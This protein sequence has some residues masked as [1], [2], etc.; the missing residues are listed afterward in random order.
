MCELD[1]MISAGCK[2]KEQG[3]AVLVFGRTG[4]LAENLKQLIVSDALCVDALSYCTPLEQVA[5]IGSVQVVIIEVNTSSDFKEVI[6]FVTKVRLQN[7][8]A[9]ISLVFAYSG[10]I[11]KV[12]CYLAGADHC[13]KLPVDH[14]EKTSLLSEMFENFESE[15][16]VRLILDQA[17]LCLFGLAK[18][19]E[20]SY[21]EMQILQALINAKEYILSHDDVAKA[22]DL[23]IKFYDPRALEKT[24]SRL[25]GKIKKTYDINAIHNVR[26]FGYR[27][28]RGVIS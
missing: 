6:E 8:S 15:S 3:T 5:N 1:L 4:A 26:G 13:I 9:Q 24:M 28:C 12:Q 10:T 16:E 20:I 7:L 11:P 27:L 17:R 23:N 2:L 14:Y 19:L 22:L 25:R 21:S 18:K